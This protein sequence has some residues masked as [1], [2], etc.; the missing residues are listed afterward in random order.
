M[1]YKKC[2]IT[3][4]NFQTRI[5]ANCFVCITILSDINF[6]TNS[7]AL[8]FKN[9]YCTLCSFGRFESFVWTINKWISVQ[10]Y[11]SRWTKATANDFYGAEWKLWNNQNV[12][13]IKMYHCT[14]T[15][16]WNDW[17]WTRAHAGPTES[18][19]ESE[20]CMQTNSNTLPVCM[21][22]IW[23]YDDNSNSSNETIDYHNVASN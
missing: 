11:E 23:L 13:F 22:N 9:S 19:T 12:L 18:W 21:L 2:K 14:P 15:H 17:N 10:L 16:Q 6:K 20:S 7:T 1:K 3:L 5:N 8:K 4:E